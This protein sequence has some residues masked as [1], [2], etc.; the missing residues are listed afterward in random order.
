MSIRSTDSMD[1]LSFD[2][3]GL[4][5]FQFI[6]DEVE[7]GRSTY[8]SNMNVYDHVVRATSRLLR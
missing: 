4:P 8:H 3:G 1:R 6:Q 5:G 2:Q 7:Y